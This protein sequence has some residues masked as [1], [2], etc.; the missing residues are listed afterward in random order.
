VCLDFALIDFDKKFRSCG[1]IDINVLEQKDDGF[2]LPVLLRN[3]E[4][5]VRRTLSE[6]TKSKIAKDSGHPTRY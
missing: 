3:S 6:L 4:S 2:S 1:D 5:R